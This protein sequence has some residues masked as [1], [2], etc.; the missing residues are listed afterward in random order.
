MPDTYPAS[1]HS[2]SLSGAFGGIRVMVMVLSVLIETPATNACS[3][4]HAA[5]LA[6]AV[7]AQALSPDSQPLAFAMCTAQLALAVKS[8]CSVLGTGGAL[9]KPVFVVR[10]FSVL[11][12]VVT[13]LL[14]AFE[15]MDDAHTGVLLLL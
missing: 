7:A 14:L 5:T 11:A 12:T 4:W 10:I 8:L 3:G 2:I 9:R 1:V 6:A 15:V 13:L